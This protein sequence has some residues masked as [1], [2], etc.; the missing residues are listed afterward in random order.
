MNPPFVPTAKYKVATMLELANP[1]PKDKMVDIG[2][3]DGRIVIAFAEKG[4]DAT[5][6]ELKEHLLQS[7]RDKATNLQLKNA[8]FFKKDFWNEKLTQYTIIVVF[9]MNSI[10]PRLQKK[11]EQEA[12]PGTKVLS[13]VFK[14]PGWKIETTKDDVNLYIVK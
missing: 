1:T 11:I 3:G 9:G 10:M 6:F 2:S 14:F 12:R 5:G 13:N 7:S 4:I 8:H